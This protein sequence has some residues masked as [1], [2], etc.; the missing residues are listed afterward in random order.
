MPESANY[1]PLFK[2]SLFYWWKALKYWL[3]KIKR[4]EFV[5]PVSDASLVICP[6][7]G[8][9]SVRSVLYELRGRC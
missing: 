2:F 6:P 7:R 4:V 8:C 1:Q 3:Q 9:P 5:H